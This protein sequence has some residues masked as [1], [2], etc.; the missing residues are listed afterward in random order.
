M[1]LLAVAAAVA[2][3]SATTSAAPPPPTPFSCDSGNYCPSCPT[4]NGSNWDSIHLMLGSAHPGLQ[5]LHR[6]MAEAVSI[7]RAAGSG[8]RSDDVSYAHMTV[9]Y[10][11]CID[12]AQ[13]LKLEA[14]V[15][16]RPFPKL[17][18]RF[19][20]VICRTS[21]FIATVDN[22]TQTTLAAWV[23]T[24]EDAMIAAGIPVLIRRRAQAP[25][26]T[27]L[28]T[29]GG[30]YPAATA[31]AAVN[32]RFGDN[33]TAGGALNTDPIAVDGAVFLPD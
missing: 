20:R 29:F 32:R 28:A 18:V 19:E 23:D 27:T 2:V 11:C 30:S 13:L 5:Q 7:F 4:G 31:M 1:P 22:A 33:A 15:A 3:V 17:V 25:F 24:V 9:Q 8:I 10:V 16:A 12:P 26:H 6:S 21:S 14:I